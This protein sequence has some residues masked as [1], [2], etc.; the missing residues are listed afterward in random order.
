MEPKK[1]PNENVRYNILTIIV[2]VIGIILL[3][4]LFNLQIIHGKEYRETSNTRLSRETVLKAARGDITDNSGNKLVTTK[5]G[6]TLELYKTKIDNQA[7]NQTIL[8]LVELLEKN[9]DTYIDNLPITVEPYAFTQTQ[10]EAQKQWKKEN[11][12]DE[13][14]TAEQVFQNLK[15]KYDIQESNVQNARKIMAVRYEITR[16]GFSNIKTVTIAKDISS[17]S[18]SQIREQASSFPGAAI[19]TQPIVIY[20]YGNLASHVLGY[21]AAISPEEYNTKKD[22]YGMSDLIGKTG[23]QYTLEDYLKGKDGTKQ[24][25]MAVDGT[26]TGEYITKEATAGSTVT[27][28]I[29]ANVQKIAEKALKDNIEELAKRNLWKKARRKSRS[30]NCNEHQNR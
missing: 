7:F 11:G 8:K 2:Y 9:K 23:I 15:E 12:I 24:V 10:E 26:I 30:S 6:F 21:V 17:V 28:T 19:G 25:E 20:P 13:N 14:A 29:D 1:K 4:Q 22:K 5:I 16:N 18:V 27:L 3:A